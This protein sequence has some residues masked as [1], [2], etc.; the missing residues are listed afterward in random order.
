[1]LKFKWENNWFCEYL[2]LKLDREFVSFK[3]RNVFL[4]DVVTIS[5]ERKYQERR[6]LIF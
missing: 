6:T 3:T 1:M 2:I 4:K 5:F